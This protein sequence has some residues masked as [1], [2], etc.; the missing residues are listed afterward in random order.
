MLNLNKFKF[1]MNRLLQ[2]NYYLHVVL[3][4]KKYVK[5]SSILNVNNKF[6][7]M[8]HVL[9][10]FLYKLNLILQFAYYRSTII[11]EFNYNFIYCCSTTTIIQFLF[12]S[13][14]AV[15]P[16]LASISIS[17]TAV[18]APSLNIFSFCLLL[19]HHY[20]IQFQFHLLLFHH[21]H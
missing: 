7:L 2:I 15:S 3:L 6:N 8:K 18:P 20:Q 21:H 17:P 9:D 14:T 5:V 1:Y 4:R 12:N 10:N 19:T 16:S 11:I 13:L